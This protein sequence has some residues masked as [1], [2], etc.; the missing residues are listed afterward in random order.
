MARYSLATSLILLAGSAITSAHA[1]GDGKHS[2]AWEFLPVTV[3][4]A[5]SDMG[6]SIITTAAAGDSSSTKRIIL[7]GGCDSELG[8][9]YKEWGDDQWFDCL[10]LSSKAYAFD[11]FRNNQFQAWNGEFKILSDM[12]R[13]RARHASAVVDG[14]VCVFGGRNETDGLIAEI[15]CYDPD[16]D[17]WSTPASLPA[18]DQ[19]SDGTGFAEEDGKVY[20]I[21]GFDPGYTALDQVTIVDMS[22]M[23]DPTSITFADGPK[24]SSARG[25]IDVARVNGDVYVSGGFTHENEWSTPKNT[26]EKYNIATATWSMVD[27]LNT[28][29]GD[30]QLVAL[31]GKVYAL[32]GE[33]KMDVRDIPKEERPK[34]G[35]RS[36][37]LDTVEVLNPGEDVHG[38]LAEWRNLA[39]MP[40]QLFRFAAVEWESEDDDEDGFIFVFGGQVGYDSECKCFR[41]TDKVMVFDVSHAEEEMGVETKSFESSGADRMAVGTVSMIFAGLLW[42]AL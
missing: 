39:G 19:T 15:D 2:D 34:L 25:D 8:N 37:I 13:K 4:T 6:A 9:E 29:R 40:G 38:G 31:N 20:L 7:T 42:F 27:S 18:K 41:T 36:E 10:S 33:R 5:L 16:T 3:P 35:V 24:L 1:D 32:G 23:A 28:E 21:G 30:K 11:P 14:N 22:N 17:T 26:V 12:P